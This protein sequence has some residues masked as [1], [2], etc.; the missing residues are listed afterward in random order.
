LQ[1]FLFI[2]AFSLCRQKSFHCLPP[3]ACRFFAIIEL[4]FTVSVD[5]FT[6]CILYKAENL[7]IDELDCG[8][9]FFDPTDG[10]Y[11]YCPKKERKNTAARHSPQSGCDLLS[12]D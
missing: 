5:K 9:D 8:L 6:I 12:L 11:E 1:K 3:A 2:A 4:N 10:R 7:R